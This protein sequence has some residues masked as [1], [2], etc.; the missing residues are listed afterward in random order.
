M[1][2]H[3]SSQLQRELGALLAR[4][5]GRIHGQDVGALIGQAALAFEVPLAVAPFPPQVQED[6]D[7]D[8]LATAHRGPKRPMMRTRR[9]PAAARPDD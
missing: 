1:Q 8:T 9:A 7:D 5:D 6:E 4:E 3:A 2:P